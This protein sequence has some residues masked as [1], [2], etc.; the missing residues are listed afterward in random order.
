[1]QAPTDQQKK[2]VEEELKSLAPHKSTTLAKLLESVA[3]RYEKASLG[4][5]SDAHLRKVLEVLRFRVAN[6][7][8]VDRVYFS[9][10]IPEPKPKVEKIVKEKKEK[11]AAKPEDSKKT[12]TDPKAEEKATTP[13]E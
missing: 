9:K 12:G 8:G 2:L 4:K 10:T 11:P 1:M 3:A 5:P 6:R 13:T 7:R